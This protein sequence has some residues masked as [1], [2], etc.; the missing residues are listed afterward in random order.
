[1]GAAGSFMWT[2][3]NGYTSL[4]TLAANAGV[5]IPDGW[6]LN[7]P[8]GMSDDGLTIVG[9]AS[10][11]QGTSPF[12][13]DLRP[14]KQPCPADLDGNGDVGATDIANLLG[15]WG[16]LGGGADLDGN[17]DV[18]PADLAILLGAWG[19]CP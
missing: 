19:A 11:P 2:A 15:Q 10:G 1:M 8:L 4:A 14:T 9:T 3:A 7:L 13:L 5:Q 12:V 18:G 6:Q 16:A 17:G